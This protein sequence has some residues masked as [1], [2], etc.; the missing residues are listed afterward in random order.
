MP[1][2]SDVLRFPIQNITTTTDLF[3]AQKLAARHDAATV[4]R[5][6]KG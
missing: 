5:E 2:D 4:M 1:V 3:Y 6:K